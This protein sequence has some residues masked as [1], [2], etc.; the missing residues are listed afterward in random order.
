[1]TNSEHLVYVAGLQA[2][3]ETLETTLTAVQK[4]TKNN[5]NSINKLSGKGGCQ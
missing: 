2:R 3:V 5:T 4:T 1:M